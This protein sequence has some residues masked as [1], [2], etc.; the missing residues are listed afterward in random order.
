MLRLSNFQV[1]EDDEWTVYS[2]GDFANQRWP[3]LLRHQKFNQF[4]GSQAEAMKKDMF[5]K[6]LK[7]MMLKYGRE[8]F[9]FVPRT[10]VLP[11]EL[12]KF[13]KYWNKKR[14]PG[15]WIYKPW[16]NGRAIGV[17]VINSMDQLPNAKVVV[18]K[19]ISK[20]YQINN[21]K[22]DI[23][24]YVY[25]SSLEPLRIYVHDISYA[26]FT[27]EKYSTE[28]NKL[29][30]KFVHITNLS[31]NKY[32]PKYQTSRHR[33]DMADVWRHMAE[34]GIDTEHVEQQIHD[35]IIKQFIS[36]EPV[37]TNMM[38][39]HAK[40]SYSCNE[41]YAYDVIIDQQLKPWLLEVNTF[42]GHGKDYFGEMVRD[43][44]NL[45]GYRIPDRSVMFSSISAF[46]NEQNGK[47]NSTL[48]SATVPNDKSYTE[49]G[50]VP[51]PQLPTSLYH[52]SL[53]MHEKIKRNHFTTNASEDEILQHIL[54][55][56]TPADV[57]E[58][59]E[60][61]DEY[62]RRGKFQ[63]IFP[64]PTSH[65]FLKYFAQKRYSNL[66]LDAWTQKYHSDDPTAG[67]AVLEAMCKNG[68][69]L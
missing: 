9:S 56:L 38:N 63:R 34:N 46:L 11:E 4:P 51:G 61:V 68:W 2:N 42:P 60:A 47:I 3:K 62:Q 10:F 27:T 32:N 24:L 59:V 53:T 26:R 15:L 12:F 65:R 13:R 20:P 28:S 30:N 52:S 45:A 48:I 29:R 67:W 64:N 54:D 69:H 8:S 49:S 23:R 66:L 44:L 40:S 57:R 36:S 58:L 35:L 14:N 6:N 25:V 41:L 5:W 43:M 18:Q 1:T 21:F 55:Y 17:E 33:W 37:L 22:F 50:K 16:N 39:A 19:Y 7:T 31:V